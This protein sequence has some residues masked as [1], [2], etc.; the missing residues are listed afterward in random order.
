VKDDV[1][2]WRLKSVRLR[3]LPD[4]RGLLEQAYPDRRSSTN[5]ALPVAL[6]ST[7]VAALVAASAA[8]LWL[9]QSDIDRE[10]TDTLVQATAMGAQLYAQHWNRV[11]KTNDQ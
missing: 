9:S 3:Q 1:L 4:P 11:M 2:I 8:P 7:A 6:A 10:R 5:N